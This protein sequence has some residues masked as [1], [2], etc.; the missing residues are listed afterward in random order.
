MYILELK[1]APICLNLCKNISK[2]MMGTQHQ[3]LGSL[4]YYYSSY[5]RNGGYILE[6]QLWSLISQEKASIVHVHA[7]QV[8]S[9]TPN[10]L[11]WTVARQ[12]PLSI[13]FS[14]QEYWSGLPFPLL[15]D[16]PKPGIEPMCLW[17]WQVDSLPLSHLGSPCSYL[18]N[19]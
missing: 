5:N 18:Y 13:Q 12:A 4:L 15:G 2:R 19:I 6:L 16:L 3:Q 9:V 10:S 7:C 1:S 17:H 11:L 8:A 14:R